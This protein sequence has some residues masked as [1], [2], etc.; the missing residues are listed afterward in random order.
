MIE[1]VALALP[2]GRGADERPLAFIVPRAGH[3][4]G[5]VHLRKLLR[6]KVPEAAI[7]GTI[8][9]LERLPLRADGSID[10]CALL[11][12]A[13]F[14]A[15]AHAAQPDADA[16]RA[17]AEALLAAAWRDMLGLT[18]ISRR[19]NF[20]ALG[21]N[22]LQSIQMIVRIEKQTGQRLNPR[23][24]LLNSLE[25]LAASLPAGPRPERQA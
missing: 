9:L 11:T 5:L 8:V 15:D 17:G 16:P 10:R 19:D 14:P 12:D 25:Q 4:P 7:P 24:V 3:E 20:F 23:H 18:A 21:G 1:Q 6:G 22:S 2:A 13:G